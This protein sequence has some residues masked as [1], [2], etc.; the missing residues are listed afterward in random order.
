MAKPVVILLDKGS[1]VGKT[2]IA[3]AVERALMKRRVDRRSVV[4]ILNH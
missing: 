4:N 1:A 3:E 2:Q